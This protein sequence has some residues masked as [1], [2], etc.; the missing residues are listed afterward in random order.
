MTG[1]LRMLVHCTVLLVGLGPARLGFVVYLMCVGLAL[2]IPGRGVSD[3]P[4]HAVVGAR[5]NRVSRSFGVRQA[6]AW[7]GNSEVEEGLQG[8]ELR[9]TRTCTG[10]E[11]GLH[12][13]IDSAST[14]L[15][16]TLLGGLKTHAKCDGEARTT[17]NRGWL[18]M[19]GIVRTDIPACLL[20]RE[21]P[22]C[23]FALS[24]PLAHQPARAPTH[25]PA[26]PLTL[27][28]ANVPFRPR[29]LSDRQLHL[30]APGHL[31]AHLSRPRLSCLPSRSPVDL[32]LAQHHLPGAGRVDLDERITQFHARG[33]TRHG[34]TTNER[35]MHGRGHT[36]G[37][38]A[39][40]T[41]MI[42]TAAASTQGKPMS[43]ITMTIVKLTTTTNTS[44]PV[45]TD[46]PLML[47]SLELARSPPSTP[48]SGIATSGMTPY[49]SDT[50]GTIRTVHAAMPRMN[51]T[52]LEAFP[53]PMTVTASKY[54][55]GEATV[56]IGIAPYKSWTGER[57]CTTQI[58]GVLGLAA[59]VSTLSPTMNN[60]ISPAH[61]YKPKCA[62]FVQCILVDHNEWE[63]FGS[64]TIVYTGVEV[65]VSPA[66]AQELPNLL[67]CLQEDF[68]E[69]SIVLW[70]HLLEAPELI[71][72]VIY[73]SMLLPLVLEFPRPG[74]LL[75]GGIIILRQDQ[76]LRFLVE[77]DC[78]LL[79]VDARIHLS[80]PRD[81]Q[82]HIFLVQIHN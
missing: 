51:T 35:T 64:Y 12:V 38:L 67:M 21:L 55:N 15:H 9:A 34:S 73:N 62:S 52:T 10:R 65:T 58:F 31:F 40:C 20:F 74:D 57:S 54:L 2:V 37:G 26:H 36:D 19:Y 30:P 46:E 50:R 49:V 33:K 53:R 39:K 6:D 8:E 59:L 60:T 29:I 23:S 11:C 63:F 27:P 48:G 41:G 47:A 79:P 71:G 56:D 78:T 76:L 4:D 80:Q 14:Q 66:D 3:A 44:Q 72:P 82:Y 24:R 28:L 5:Y 17:R 68:G 16:A 61:D 75:K 42:R 1:C 18:A 45:V 32:P 77:H 70:H 22:A 43:E 13:N 25:S 7:R 81:T 69:V